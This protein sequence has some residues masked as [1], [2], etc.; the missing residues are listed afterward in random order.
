MQEC[1][2]DNVFCNATKH[3]EHFG[4]LLR[5]SLLRILILEMTGLSTYMKMRSIKSTRAL[6]S[7]DIVFFFLTLQLHR[8]WIRSET[9]LWQGTTCS[10]MGEAQ[11]TWIKG[12]LHTWGRLCLWKKWKKSPSI[13]P[14]QNTLGCQTWRGP[15]RFTDGKGSYWKG[16]REELTLGCHLSLLS[17]RLELFAWLHLNL[18]FCCQ[19]S[20]DQANGTSVCS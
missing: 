13:F 8:W 11:R 4:G 5:N 3:Y 2:A 15:W 19:K 7:S 6:P 14:H 9:V 18:M 12:P 1:Q 17:P 20:L 16:Q 10:E